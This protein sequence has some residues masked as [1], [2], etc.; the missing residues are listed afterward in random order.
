MCCTSSKCMYLYLDYD[1]NRI[2]RGVP[3]SIEEGRMAFP[4]LCNTVE[5]KG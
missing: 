1:K 2:A 5:M 4:D 3:L